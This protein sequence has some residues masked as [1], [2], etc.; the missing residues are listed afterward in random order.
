M[1]SMRFFEGFMPLQMLVELA[2]VLGIFSLISYGFEKVGLKLNK[3]FQAVVLLA[4]CVWYLK[5]RLYP[6]LPMTMVQMYTVVAGIGIFGWVSSNEAY[7]EEVRQPIV[8][9]LD[10]ATLLARAARI[11]V[12]VALPLLLGDYAYSVMKPGDVNVDAPVELRIYHPAPPSKIVVY[13]PEDFK[14]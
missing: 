9:V 8:A 3:L 13:S 7:W 12:V 2:V 1:T 11:I 4:F 14:R 5:I 10:G 6:P